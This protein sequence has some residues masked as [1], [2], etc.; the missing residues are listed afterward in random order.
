VK[1][2]SDG[3]VKTIRAYLAYVEGELAKRPKSSFRY[4]KENYARRF[5]PYLQ[6]ERT[7]AE[8]LAAAKRRLPEM[9]REMAALARKILPD[10]P[11]DDHAAIR[12][13][14]AEVA[15]D[16][17]APE[18]LF[19]TVKQD[20]TEARAFVRDQKLLTLPEHD[21]LQV[22]ETPPFLRSQFGV[23]AFDGAPPL[24]PQLGAFYYVTPFPKEWPKERV[25]SKLREYN[26][27]MLQLLTIHEA[28]PGHYVQFEHANAV[29]PEWRRTLRRVLGAAAYIE[30]WAVYAQDMMVDA[31]YLAGDPRLRFTNDK[32]E[33]RVIANTI[34][35]V[36][37]QAGEMSDEQAMKLMLEEAF[38]EKPEAEAKLRRAKLSVTQLCSYFVG[39][40][41]W[42][43]LRQKARVTAGPDLRAYHDRVLAGGAVTLGTLAGK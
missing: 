41:A 18:A 27:W 24:E 37:L 16:H 36:E 40:E 14:L 6:T 43:A 32:M 7:P 15:K 13:A 4:G 38:Q 34:L 11:K 26:H 39:A 21:N 28:M 22:I 19:S 29:Q 5:G 1:S 33:L 10:A 25:E 17:P 8:V 3:A 9:Q 35:D 2:A 31:G 30:G 20:L 12:A 23:G 42:R